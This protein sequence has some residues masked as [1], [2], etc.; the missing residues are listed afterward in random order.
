VAYSHII[1]RDDRNAPPISRQEKAPLEGF[2]DNL[3]NL[4][5]PPWRLEEGKNSAGT[6]PRGQQIVEP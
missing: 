4:D 3:A 1:R 2:E 5:T 6:A